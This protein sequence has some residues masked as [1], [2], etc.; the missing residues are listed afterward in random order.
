LYIIIIELKKRDAIEKNSKKIAVKIII[1]RRRYTFIKAF[2][3]G[4]FT[5]TPSVNNNNF[6]AISTERVLNFF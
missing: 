6:T 1:N 5:G 3:N 4:I 2:D